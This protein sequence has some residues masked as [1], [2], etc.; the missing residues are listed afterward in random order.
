[1][2]TVLGPNSNCGSQGQRKLFHSADVKL[3]MAQIVAGELHNKSVNALFPWLFNPPTTMQHG[4]SN[5]FLFILYAVFILVLL[6]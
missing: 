6:K 4:Y 3:S 5:A 1:M 2:D